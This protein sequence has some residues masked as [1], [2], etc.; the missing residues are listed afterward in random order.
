MILKNYDVLIIG[1]GPAGAY[2]AYKLKNQGCSVL[3]IEKDTFPRYKICA[4]G[5]SKKAYDILHAEIN[6]FDKIIEKETKKTLYVR[7]KFIQRKSED[8]LIYMTYRSDFDLSLL[9]LATSDNNVTFID[10]VEQ[11]K[12][13]KNENSIDL[14]L[15]NKIHNI[16]YKVL[17][18]AWGTN[19]RLNNLVDINPFERFSVSSSWEGPCTSKFKKYFNE[20]SMCHILKNYPGFVGYIFPKKDKITAGVFTS[21]FPIPLN[22]KK[23]WMDFAYFWDLDIKIKPNYALI[24]IRNFK[25]PIAKQNVLL[26]GDAAGLAD[27]FTGEGIYYALISS[28]IASKH[29]PNYLKD[30]NYDLAKFYNKDIKARLLEIQKWAKIYEFF[31]HHFPNISFWLG[32]EWKTGNKVVNSFI[33]GK[34]KYNEIQKIIKLVIKNIFQSQ[35]S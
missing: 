19:I 5:L 35:I 8:G 25:K 2:L 13:K 21:I 4:G 34:I 12:I 28:E 31:F 17:I 32:S 10:N 29:I 24:P 20:Y 33:T 16:K 7:K 18:G 1:A 22:I 14:K 3:I 26:V 11:L 27:P 6:E 23:M 30:K 15:K 9:K